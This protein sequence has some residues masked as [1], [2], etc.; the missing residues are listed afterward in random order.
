MM[1]DMEA[2]LSEYARLAIRTG[3]NLRKGQPLVVNAPIECAD[4]ARRLA[5]E[6]YAAGAKD[7]TICWG[8]E[9]FSRIRY[10]LASEDALASYPD[11]RRRFYMDNAED[12][13]AIVSIHAEDPEAFLGVE[14]SRL[15]MAQQAAGEAL[16]EY[17]ARI[18]SNKNA[19][20]VVSVPTEAWA[21]K[22]YPDKSGAEAVEALW[23]AILSAV[24]VAGS[25]DA[26]A[27]WKE[28]TDFL[29][30]ASDFMNG[31][32]FD[33]LHYK[34]GLGTDLTVRLP[35]GHIW[36]GGA[37]ETQ[38]GRIFVANLPTEE[39][40]TLPMRNGVDGT[41][42]ATKP[43]VF[44]GNLI[45]GMKFRFAAGKVVSFEAEK[46]R[47]HLEKLLKTDEGSARLG[48]VALVPYDSPISKSGVLFYN[49]L[50]DE[51]A[52]CH[53]ALGK[54]YPTCLAGGADMDSVT[55]LSRGVND[56][57]LHE[58]FM[59]GSR[60]LTITGTTKDGREVPVFRDGNFVEF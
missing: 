54:A 13:A 31:W 23:E 41:V 34:N 29:R 8:D 36:A 18:M 37:E 6:A 38:N 43:L 14:P 20:C 40:Y 22:I 45:T 4:F 58:D 48:E 5:K 33:F 51:N 10:E 39:V 1:G 47:A 35:E 19:W 46:G 59:V 32:A 27:R 3:V 9:R 11:W 55:L 52:S 44:Q 17:R 42:V 24:R 53:L 7:V 60:D 12:D 16:L 26:E 49:T 30:R 50:F 21:R 15:A 2:R 25:G 57:L 28:H 56:S